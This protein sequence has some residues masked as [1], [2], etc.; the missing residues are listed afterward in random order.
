MAE[1][2]PEPSGNHRLREMDTS[3]IDHAVRI[4]GAP[5]RWL[6]AWIRGRV[7]SEETGKER[8]RGQLR[9][10]SSSMSDAMAASAKIGRGMV[11]D[12]AFRQ[13]LNLAQLR[14]GE[15]AAQ[16]PDASLRE[17]ASTFRAAA[18]ALLDDSDSTPWADRLARLRLAHETVLGRV[19]KMTDELG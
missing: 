10:L 4:A 9:E 18:Q 12:G 14:A 19:A 6:G 2:R 7:V 8:K 13:D 15:L 1:E 5:L 3:L 16:I 11:R 17:G